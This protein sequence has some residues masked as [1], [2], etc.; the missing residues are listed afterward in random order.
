M[1]SHLEVDRKNNLVE[2]ETP[3]TK[4]PPI[5]RNVARIIS[6]I[7][8]P[9]FIPVYLSWLVVQTQSYLFAS[10]SNWE[11]TLFII[12]FGVMYVMFPLVSVLLMKALGFISSIHLKTQRD[13]IIPYVVCMIYYWWMWYVLHNQPQYPNEFVILSL[14]IFLASI[15]GLMANINMKI[16][17]HAIAAGVMA[18][19]VMV[20]GLSQDVNFGVYISLSV[21]LAGCI[22]TARLIDGD[23]TAR[24]IYWGLFIGVLSLIIAV[25]FA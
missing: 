4:Y 21:L 20:L 22:C 12:R 3:K 24:E 7:F 18:A 8:H 2:I 17:M 15:G 1:E 11:K 13:R 5:V 9:L 14:A 23:H 19:F 16:S 10:F 6:Y 25:K